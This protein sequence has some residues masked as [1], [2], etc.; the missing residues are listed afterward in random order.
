MMGDED[1]KDK[2]KRWDKKWDYIKELKKYI[3]Y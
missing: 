2:M 1:K 3:E